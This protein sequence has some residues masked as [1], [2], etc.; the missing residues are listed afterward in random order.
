MPSMANSHVSILMRPFQ[1]KSAFF[2][3]FYGVFVQR[4]G[5]DGPETRRAC[6]ISCGVMLCTYKLT[7]PGLRAGRDTHAGPA[8]HR[9]PWPERRYCFH[10][11][12]RGGGP[13]L[14]GV[15][16]RVRAQRAQ[17]LPAAEPRRGTRGGRGGRWAAWSGPIRHDARRHK[18]VIRSLD[19][20]AAKRVLPCRV[21]PAEATGQPG[22]HLSVG[23]PGGPEA[24]TIRHDGEPGRHGCR[25]MRA[26]A[27]RDRRCLGAMGGNHPEP[28]RDC[29]PGTIALRRYSD[30]PWSWSAPRGL[31]AN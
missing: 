13:G 6:G 28:R 5:G 15:L 25:P 4:G 19:A 11:R 9:L 21:L 12:G 24:A 2:P 17:L 8:R 10:S 16:S 23:V 18:P 7:L 14:R 26:G 1:E 27:R 30:S 22:C 20:R 3:H 31:S 29:E